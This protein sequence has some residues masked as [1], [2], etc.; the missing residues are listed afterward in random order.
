MKE[1]P[2]VRACAA[3]A[4]GKLKLPEAREILQRAS[5]DKELVVR[6]AVSRALREAT[7]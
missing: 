2:E 7:K 3:M 4:L 5:E 1:R 6:N